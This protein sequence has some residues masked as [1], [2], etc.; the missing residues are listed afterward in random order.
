MRAVMITGLLTVLHPQTRPQLATGVVGVEIG[1]VLHEFI[2]VPT[3][4][5]AERP[6]PLLGEGWSVEPS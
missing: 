2:A 4:T 5:R 1:Q 3:I 6:G